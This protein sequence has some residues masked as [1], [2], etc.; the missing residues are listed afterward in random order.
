MPKVEENDQ[1]EKLSRQYADFVISR[2]E[3]N[4]RRRTLLDE[5][6]AKYNN[7]HYLAS[8]IMSEIKSKLKDAVQF[9]K[10]YK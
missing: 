9:V 4:K 7:R 5:V 3:Y 8:E 6:D 1:L 2:E 10:K